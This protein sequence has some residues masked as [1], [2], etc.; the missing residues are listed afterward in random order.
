MK[1][2]NL[3]LFLLTGAVGGREHGNGS[4][5]VGGGAL[6]RGSSSSVEHAAGIPLLAGA[7]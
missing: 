1:I 5:D 7:G 3:P 2:F 6:R 4:D